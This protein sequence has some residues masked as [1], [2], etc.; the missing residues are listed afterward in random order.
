MIKSHKSWRKVPRGHECHLTWI[1]TSDT[2]VF[3]QVEGY[4]G[5]ESERSS[6]ESRQP[7]QVA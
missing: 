7:R 3:E 4:T 1:L 6:R 5:R 2:N